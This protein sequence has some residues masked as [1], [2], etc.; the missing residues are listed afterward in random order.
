MFP[1]AALLLSEDGKAGYS[2]GPQQEMFSFDQQIMQQG[3]QAISTDALLTVLRG[4]S[5]VYARLL[6]GQAVTQDEQEQFYANLEG[7]EQLQKGQMP[8]EGPVMF[9]SKSLSVEENELG[10]L[11]TVALIGQNSAQQWIQQQVQFQMV[12]HNQR[13]YVLHFKA[14][15]I[16]E[17]Y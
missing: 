1:A 6:L 10:Q 3:Q 13:W 16:G 17:A 2:S 5:S 15:E 7:L 12:E 14:G 11:C 9:W 8:T 4:A